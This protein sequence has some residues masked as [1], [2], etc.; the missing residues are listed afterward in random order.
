[1]ITEYAVEDH[2]K[3]AKRNCKVIIAFRTTKCSP[4]SVSDLCSQ[5]KVNLTFVTAFSCI[6]DILTVN[7]SSFT[8]TTEV[9]SAIPPKIMRFG[10]SGCCFLNKN[11]ADSNLFFKRIIASAINKVRQ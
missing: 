10:I 6:L 3:L 4:K 11:F 7:D 5:I 8:S 9:F 2:K 1:M